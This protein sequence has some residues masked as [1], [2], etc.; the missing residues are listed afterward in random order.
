MQKNLQSDDLE[1][2]STHIKCK[3]KNL[4]IE[5]TLE[6]TLVEKNDN[7]FMIDTKEGLLSGGYPTNFPASG[8]QIGAKIKVYY[9]GVILETYPGQIHM[10]TKIERI[11][12]LFFLTERNNIYMKKIKKILCGILMASCMKNVNLMRYKNRDRL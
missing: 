6:G 1:S 8:I 9:T 11:D 2:N 3:K 5:E 10:V 4:I 12:W 7:F